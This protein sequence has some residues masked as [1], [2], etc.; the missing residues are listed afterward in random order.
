MVMQEIISALTARQ[1]LS[2]IFGDCFGKQTGCTVKETRTVRDELIHIEIKFSRRWTYKNRVFQS[3]PGHMPETT[4]SYDWIGVPLPE[5][6]YSFVQTVN[7]VC[8]S[9]DGRYKIQITHFWR[10]VHSLSD[11]LSE[12]FRVSW[13]KMP[14]RFLTTLGIDF[15]T[16]LRRETTCLGQYDNHI[17]AFEAVSV[18]NFQA[19][20]AELRDM[21]ES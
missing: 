6:R 20:P 4:S 8:D 10:P 13:Y 16:G 5:N 3:Q 11:L 18:P 12:H 19:M 2:R 17:A 7:I 9:S 21:L 14:W 15:R 1:I